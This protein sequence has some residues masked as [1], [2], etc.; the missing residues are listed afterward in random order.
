MLRTERESPPRCAGI[1]QPIEQRLDAVHQRI[2][3][4]QSEALAQSG[5][6]SIN[7]A[8]GQGAGVDGDADAGRASGWSAARRAR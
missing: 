1:R 7:L 4:G 5:Q 8:C 6:I 2:D 3:A